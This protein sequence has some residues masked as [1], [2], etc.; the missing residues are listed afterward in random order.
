MSTM[1]HNSPDDGLLQTGGEGVSNFCD[2]VRGKH[3]WRLSYFPSSAISWKRKGHHLSR[4]VVSHC[5][6]Q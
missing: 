5:F 4:E 3:V 6:L 2:E 1:V